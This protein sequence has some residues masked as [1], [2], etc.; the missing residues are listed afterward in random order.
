MVNKKKVGETESIRKPKNYVESV[1]MANK[2]L[3]SHTK[4]LI[5][6]I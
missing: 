1:P 6:K 2:K 3:S 4:V 5:K